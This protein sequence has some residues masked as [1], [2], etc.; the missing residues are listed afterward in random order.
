M[1]NFE[2][3]RAIRLIHANLFIDMDTEDNI[4]IPVSGTYAEKVHETLNRVQKN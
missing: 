4:R 3:V 1:V 2:N